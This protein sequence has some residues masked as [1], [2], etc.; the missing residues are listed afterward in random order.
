MKVTVKK[1]GRVME[2]CPEGEIDQH[3][4]GELRERLDSELED[5]RIDRVEYDM[6]AVSFMDSSGIGVLL[7]RYRTISARG[8]TMDVKNARRNVELILRMAGVYSLCTE[9]SRQ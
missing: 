5:K 2:V 6:K 1:R 8:G 7:G 3:S 4:A 9:R